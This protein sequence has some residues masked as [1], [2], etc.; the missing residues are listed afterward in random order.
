MLG[1]KEGPDR[2]APGHKLYEAYRDAPKESPLGQEILRAM[3]GYYAAAYEAASNRSSSASL[4]KSASDRSYHSLMGPRGPKPG[5]GLSDAPSAASANQS[6]PGNST[7]NPPSTRSANRQPGGNLS[8]TFIASPFGLIVTESSEKEYTKANPGDQ[9]A[10]N[11]IDQRGTETKGP[12]VV[13]KPNE[14]RETQRVRAR[15]SG[16]DL[17]S[18]SD[19]DANSADKGRMGQAGA[20][21]VRGQNANG[22]QPQ[23]RD[24]AGRNAGV[25]A[26]RDIPAKSG[27]NYAFSTSDLSYEGSWFKKAEQNLEAIE[28]LLSL[29][30]DGRQATR[31]EQAKLAKFIGWGASEIAN[32]LF[33]DK[34]DKAAETLTNYDE[35]I[36]ALGDRPFLTNARYSEYIPA[37]RVLQYRNPQLTWYTAGNWSSP[38]H[39]TL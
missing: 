6:P 35:A 26:G 2:M 33:G 39:R 18:G 8:G 7:K 1:A 19:A 9:N 4:K 25:P 36:A 13:S 37:F 16:P 38:I 28:L 15:S 17:F 22:K 34:L 14:G 27:R 24:R 11:F 23:P 32:N 21:G 30:K 29:E 10:N 5:R 31:E 12:G 20:N 3:L